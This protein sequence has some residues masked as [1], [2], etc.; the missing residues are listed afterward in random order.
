MEFTGIVLVIEHKTIY[1]QPDGLF[2]QLGG[3]TGCKGHLYDQYPC[4]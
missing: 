1:P 2:G 4:A 3:R